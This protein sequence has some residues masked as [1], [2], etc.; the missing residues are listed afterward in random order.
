MSHSRQLDSVGKPL[1]VP[2]RVSTRFS[3][4]QEKLTPTVTGKKLNRQ[5]RAPPAFNKKGCNVDLKGYS[6]DLKGYSV[7]LKGCN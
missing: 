6:V 1:S 7:N 2:T 3:G 5:H 4:F